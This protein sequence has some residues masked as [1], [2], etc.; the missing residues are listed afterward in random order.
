MRNTFGIFCAAFCCAFL[1]GCPA[2][3]PVTPPS[4]DASDASALGETATPACDASAACANACAALAAATCPLGGAQ[5]CP[6]FMQT[7]SSAGQPG[8]TGGGLANKATGHALTCD[9]AAKVK[10]KADAI[11]LG[12]VCQ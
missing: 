11:A 10:T 1:A 5:G 12:F 9:D 2:P 6:C 7:L 4:P 3:A 8:G